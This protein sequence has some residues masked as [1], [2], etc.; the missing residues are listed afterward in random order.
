[1][2]MRVEYTLVETFSQCQKSEKALKKHVHFPNEVTDGFT[3]I[4]FVL[5]ITW[6][7]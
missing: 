4:D 2:K 5:V 6:S 3:A 7:R 1:M